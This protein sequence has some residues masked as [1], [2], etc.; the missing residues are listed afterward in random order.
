M[1]PVDFTAHIRQLSHRSILHIPVRF[2]ARICKIWARTLEGMANDCPGWCKLEVGR[3]RHLLAGIP[4][5]A[6]VETEI[7]RRIDAG[8]YVKLLC[9]VE[10]QLVAMKG[11]GPK[12]SRNQEDVASAKARKC[13]RRVHMWPTAKHCT[14][15]LMISPFCRTAS[16]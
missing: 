8:D 10:S 12:T 1:L 2:R 11:K 9:R 3:V 13:R 16:R 5:G 4:Q 14:V 6:H 15:S 7:G